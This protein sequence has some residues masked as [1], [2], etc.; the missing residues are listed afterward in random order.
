MDKV[1]LNKVERIELVALH[2]GSF[3]VPVLVSMAFFLIEDEGIIK[4]SAKNN[5]NFQ[6]SILIYLFISFILS[7]VVIGILGVVIFPVMFYILTLVS[8]INCCNGNLYEFPMTIKFI[9]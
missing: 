1:E 3:F 6:L 7:L 5:L 4:Q 8:L 2:L 9:K